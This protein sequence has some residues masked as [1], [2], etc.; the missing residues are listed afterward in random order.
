MAVTTSITQFASRIH[1]N[2]HKQLLKGVHYDII[3]IG[4]CIE[5][6]RM[7]DECELGMD[8]DYLNQVLAYIDDSVGYNLMMIATVC[9]KESCLEMIEEYKQSRPVD[10]KILGLTVEKLLATNPLHA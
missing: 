9:S 1:Q 6:D 5:L 3:R 2:Q 7:H 10:W 8:T 4:K